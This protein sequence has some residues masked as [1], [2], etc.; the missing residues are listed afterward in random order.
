MNIATIIGILLGVGL[1]S[2]AIY[3]EAGTFVYFINISG[4]VIV[5]GGTAASTL[6]SYPI[7]DVF[8]VIR[9]GFIVLKKEP[10]KLHDYLGQIL[11]L[12]RI[13]RKKGTLFLEQEL[14]NISNLFLRDA[15]QM[16][17][18]G[19]SVEEITEILDERILYKQERELMEA[20][21]FQTMGKFSPAFGMIGTLIGLILLLVNMNAAGM[22]AIGPGMAV[23]LITTFYGVIFANLIFKPFAVKL[24]RRTR[25]QTIMMRMVKESI[26][27]IA[28]QWHPTKVEDYLNSFL[29]PG[30]RQI[31]DRKQFQEERGEYMHR[32][33][34]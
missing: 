21:I 20:E 9:V 5:F 12:V 3:H 7:N 8:N 17:V 16:L 26:L 33:T 11:H 30:E 1:T 15:V 14:A 2:G 23:A 19:Y 6:V 28:E 24:Q 32:A 27:M 4:L 29:K 18:D 22:D 31:P 13:A 34:A 10:A 25:E